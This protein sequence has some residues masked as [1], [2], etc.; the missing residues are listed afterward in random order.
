MY[1]HLMYGSCNSIERAQEAHTMAPSSGQDT[2][3][4]KRSNLHHVNGSF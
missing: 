3:K 2:A 1:F 4:K